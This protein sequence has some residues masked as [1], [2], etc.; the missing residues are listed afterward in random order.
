[1]LREDVDAAEREV[2]ALEPA[3]REI[4]SHRRQ[5]ARLA[6]A[7]ALAQALHARSLEHRQTQQRYRSAL[8]TRDIAQDPDLLRLAEQARACKARVD[9]S[10]RRVEQL[11][12][13]EAVAVRQGE[14]RR[15]LLEG[16]RQ[17]EALVTRR[18]VDA[19]QDPDVDPNLVER[20]RD[21]L[22]EKVES[23]EERGRACE[24]RADE[25]DRQLARLLP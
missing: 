2:Q 3:L 15:R 21:E 17:Q 14:E 25:S 16:L 1:V 18:A 6:D 5:L 12:G 19:F 10:E 13:E 9:A 24:R 4:D 8:E 7:G 22:D 23:L 20:H 11:I